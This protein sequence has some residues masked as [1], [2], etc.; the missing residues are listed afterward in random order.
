MLKQVN[1]PFT[2]P[3]SHELC[4]ERARWLVGRSCVGRESRVGVGGDLDLG[5]FEDSGI[6]GK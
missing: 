1:D 2:T 6:D 3:L 4:G 5:Y